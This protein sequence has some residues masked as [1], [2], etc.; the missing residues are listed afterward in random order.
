MDI[1]HGGIDGLLRGIGFLGPGLFA[2]G[3]M[4]RLRNK[5]KKLPPGVLPQ[6][7]PITRLAGL[8]Q[9]PEPEPEPPPSWLSSPVIS[10]A[11]LP[12]FYWPLVT[13]L[14][15]WTRF[16]FHIMPPHKGCNIIVMIQYQPG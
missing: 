5:E 2:H 12:S 1:F 6:G 7:E 9:P 14:L 10:C 15:R 16:L 4:V 3:F 8:I 11:S 13:P